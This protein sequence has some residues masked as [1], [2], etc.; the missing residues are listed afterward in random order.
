MCF[1]MEEKVFVSPLWR[2]IILKSDNWGVLCFRVLNRTLVKIAGLK[3]IVLEESLHIKDSC[4]V[5][6]VLS[7]GIYDLFVRAGNAV[8]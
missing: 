5:L 2:K 4:N 6:Q 3:I 1:K 8:T 7:A